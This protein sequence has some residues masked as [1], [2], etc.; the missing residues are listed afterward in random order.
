MVNTKPTPPAIT[1]NGNILHSDIM[2]GNQWYNQ[3][4]LINGATNQ[5]YTV[6]ANGD[7]FVIVTIN[8]CN[9]EPSNTLNVISIGIEFTSDNKSIK[10]YPNP[11]SDELIIEMEGSTHKTDFEILNSI[12]KIVLKGSLT[13]K[14][15]VQTTIFPPGVY[16][17]KIENGNTFEFKK[18]VKE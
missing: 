5:D 2:N 16:L 4:G 1:R 8:G 15:V 7:Y 10:V 14:T 17:I 12:G 9:S 13:E 6:T 3:N 18:I 11:V